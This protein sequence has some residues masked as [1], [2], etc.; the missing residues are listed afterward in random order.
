[1]EDYATKKFAVFKRSNEPKCG[2]FSFYIIR[3]GCINDYLK[4]GYFPIADL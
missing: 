2:L 3:L 1:M 4:K